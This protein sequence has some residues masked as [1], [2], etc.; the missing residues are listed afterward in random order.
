LAHKNFA[1]PR[2]KNKVYLLGNGVFKSM[3][4]LLVF[5]SD[6]TFRTSKIRI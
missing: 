3:F 6:L 2:L 5:A 1:P 4:S